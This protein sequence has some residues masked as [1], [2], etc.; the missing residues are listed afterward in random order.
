MMF[1][2]ISGPSRRTGYAAVEPWASIIM[3]PIHR[4]YKVIVTFTFFNIIIIIIII[5][6]ILFSNIKNWVLF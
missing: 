3:P 1:Y 2:L 6:T 4:Q 5:I